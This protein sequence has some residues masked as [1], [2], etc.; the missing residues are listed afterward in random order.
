ML[1]HIDTC[2]IGGGVIGLAI[3]RVLSKKTDSLFVLEQNKSFGQ[4]IS[5]R[6]SEVV[7]AGIYY[8]KGSLKADLCTKGNPALYQYCESRKIPFK[9]CGKLIFSQSDIES[10]EELKSRAELNGVVDLKFWNS[11]SLQKYEP[12]LSAKHVLYSP[13]T[14]IVDSH[15]LMSAFVADLS[16]NGAQVVYNTQVDAIS[17][18]NGHFLIYCN[19]SGDSYQFTAR[20]LV[21]AAGLSAQNLARQCDFVDPST[22]PKLYPCKGT[23]LHFS[24]KNPFKQLIYPLPEKN[25]VGLGVHATIDI[26]GQLKF[27]PN[28]EYIERE[29]YSLD[30]GLIQNYYREIREFF[31]DLKC[32]QL[33][34]GYAGIRPKLQGPDDAV[35]DFAIQSAD[36]HGT[37]GFVQLFGIESPGL[38]ASLAIADYVEEKLRDSF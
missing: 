13:S 11:V 38:T 30:E 4:G 1:D 27:G 3:A 32:D 29:D 9:R 2:I 22:I 7:H 16:D 31:P 12:A 37:R 6:N 14:G 5:S 24:G 28:S 25:T 8:P 34:L 36:L 35:K 15:G 20:V 33:Q 18:Q 19:I 23:Y 26:G 21:N 10:L 17:L